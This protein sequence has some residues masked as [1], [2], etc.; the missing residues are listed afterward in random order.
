MNKFRVVL[1]A[2][3]GVALSM[4][5]GAGCASAAGGTISGT[6]K[7][8]RH[9]ARAQAG[10]SHQGQGSLRAASALSG[11]PDRRQRRRNRQRGRDREGRQGRHEARRRDLRSEG[12]PLRAA[13]ARIPGRQH[14]EDRELGRDPAQHP[15]LLDKNPSF[16]MAQP[17]FKKVIEQKID[18]PEV[19]KVTCDAHGWMHGWWV[20]DRHS[21]FRGDRRQGQLHDQGRAAGRLHRRGMAGEARHRGCRRPA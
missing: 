2:C 11:R 4:S 19:I 8:R 14:R 6:V 16:N 18:K 21:V 10:R 3:A 15:H 5:F 9:R 20:V 12:M 13:C 17:K 7:Y 1:A